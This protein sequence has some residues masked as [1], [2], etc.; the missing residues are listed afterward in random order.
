MGLIRGV[1]E[2]G[3]SRLLGGEMGFLPGE[4]AMGWVGGGG[5]REGDIYERGGEGR[6]KRSYSLPRSEAGWL[7]GP[8]VP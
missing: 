3:K 8:A 5:R 1:G 2:S 4:F 7:V 6:M